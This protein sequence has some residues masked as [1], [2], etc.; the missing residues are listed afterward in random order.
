MNELQNTRFD[1]VL[2]SKASKLIVSTT[3]NL[4]YQEMV[5]NLLGLQVT[6]RGQWKH[7][8]AEPQIQRKAGLVVKQRVPDAKYGKAIYLAET[9][10]YEVW[11]RL[12]V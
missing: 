7:D 1:V 9:P 8:F 10:T 2:I 4:S 5:N 3:N 6:Y 12:N 11:I